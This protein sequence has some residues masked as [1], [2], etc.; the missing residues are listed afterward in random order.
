MVS[1]AA[2][3]KWYNWH[4]ASS[5]LQF[6]AAD[7]GG[8][9]GRVIEFKANDNGDAASCGWNM[10]NA[11]MLGKF[12]SATLSFKYYKVGGGSYK[13]RLTAGGDFDYIIPESEPGKWHTATISIPEFAEGVVSQR[14]KDNYSNG[15]GYLFSIILTGGSEGDVI[16]FDEIK[17][18]GLDESWK[19]P[20]K[21]Y[22]GPESVPTPVHDADKVMSFYS[23]YPS[24]GVNFNFSNGT[25]GESTKGS[26]SM[27]NDSP[28]IEVSN[29]N[30]IGLVDFNIDIS[31]YDYMH[32]DFWT[33]TEG[34][35]F[36]VT[37]VTPGPIERIWDAGTV[38]TGEWNQYDIPL[39]YYIDGGVILSNIFQIKFCNGQ[40]NQGYIANI[41]FWKDDKGTDP[42]PEQPGDDESGITSTATIN[43]CKIPGSEATSLEV[44]LNTTVKYN[45]DKTITVSFTADKEEFYSIEG[46]VPQIFVEGAYKGDLSRSG[47]TYSISF[48]EYKA[49]D[50]VNM[51]YYMAYAGGATAF[52]QF[53]YT[54][55]SD[56]T[57]EEPENPG[58]EDPEEP[59]DGLVYE[60]SY[61]DVYTQTLNEVSKEY[62]YTL[63]YSITY[64][65]DK[66]LTIKGHYDFPNGA[67]E[68]YNRGM[69]IEIPGKWNNSG[70]E[71]EGDNKVFSTAPTTFES[72]ETWNITFQTDVALGNVRTVVTYVVGSTNNEEVAYYLEGS[73]TGDKGQNVSFTFD[74]AEEGVY[75]LS[76]GKIAA[77]DSFVLKST[78]GKSF[79]YDAGN[80]TLN[81]GVAKEIPLRE[82]ESPM[83]LDGDYVNLTF[84]WWP[85][86]LT[87]N[88]EGTA[89]ESD[90]WDVH[91]GNDKSN[92]SGQYN[93]ESHVIST[94]NSYEN[95]KGET[96]YVGVIYV[97]AP[98]A[99]A[100]IYYKNVITGDG[101]SGVR[102]Y[103]PEDGYTELKAN[104]D[105]D[106]AVVI[107]VEANSVVSGNI[108]LYYTDADDIRSDN[109]H[110]ISYIIRQEQPTGVDEV[111]AAEGE[112][113]YFTLQGEKVK[114]PERGIFIRVQN[115]KAVKV[116]K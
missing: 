87:L 112:A 1:D 22:T 94:A 107:P 89:V 58:G 57:G 11:D 100:H 51:N 71:N 63:T 53:S 75:I 97:K 114:N 39:S 18:T 17:Y 60:G 93:G 62:P 102:A 4:N 86:T 29:F 42:D 25:W 84:T 28:I 90:D 66:T 16:Y 30:Y 38:K 5:N 36:G 105:G 56:S 2:N 43:N 78:D 96:V 44:T 15:S 55:P 69:F 82:G 61:S 40:F 50:V 99:A 85:A 10:E 35:A 76:V 33:P 88:V 14:W 9:T 108:D 101:K 103:A 111:G 49:G 95:E 92:Q 68:G 79:T 54:I 113:E 59:G 12:H 37:P 116:V 21:E 8:V 77:G 52:P 31:P 73:M 81:N 109:T 6:D 104:A 80:I 27:I 48:G 65:A 45:T 47:K 7:L 20:E 24:E 34:A 23:N 46:L 115:G 70:S 83:N 98:S 19:V 91:Y 13:I 64:E 72:G 3:L 32:V 67:P 74:K 110:T 26:K 41:Y 106:Y